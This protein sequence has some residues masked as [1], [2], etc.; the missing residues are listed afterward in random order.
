MSCLVN[1]AWEG[2]NARKFRSAQSC[3]GFAL[4]L[5]GEKFLALFSFGNHVCVYSFFGL[6]DIY[7]KS[8]KDAMSC[9]AI[10]CD[11]AR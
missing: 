4:V 5:P 8:K 1:A 7:L 11:V 10:G 2:A 6:P 9:L 3:V